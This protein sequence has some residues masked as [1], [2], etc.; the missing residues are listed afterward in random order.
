MLWNRLQ[1]Q[2]VRRQQLD[3]LKQG[4]TTAQPE[5]HT[6]FLAIS[7]VEAINQR[8][9]PV[10]RRTRR[11]AAEYAPVPIH[12][13]LGWSQPQPATLAT[14]LATVVRRLHTQP[15]GAPQYLRHLRSI[16]W[17]WG[18]LQGAL[19]TAAGVAAGEMSF[20]GIE[21]SDAWLGQGHTTSRPCAGASMA[22]RGGQQLLRDEH[23]KDEALRSSAGCR[24]RQR[25]A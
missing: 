17:R 22:P 19:Q 4:Q 13:V 10:A 6:S 9:A 21:R 2:S 12:E 5:H 3:D 23:K 16:W 24:R 11:T 7:S 14:E 25:A 20:R 15:Y 8:A 18:F 1:K